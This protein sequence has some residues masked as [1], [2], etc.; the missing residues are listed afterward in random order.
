MRCSTWELPQP[1]QC[2][3]LLRTLQ[4]TASMAQL[5]GDAALDAGEAFRVVATASASG[6]TSSTQAT[7]SP[8]AIRLAAPTIAD[9]ELITIVL[10]AGVRITWGAPSGPAAGTVTYYYK[11]TQDTLLGG[12]RVISEGS[13]TD[14]TVDAAFLGLTVLGVNDKVEVEVRAAASGWTASRYVKYRLT[15]QGAL[16][17]FVID[18]LT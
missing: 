12:R 7:L 8:I 15:Y 10:A 13:G 18:L 4:V 14:S 9:A 17:G 5:S 6:Y 1:F 11:L 3:A 2:T 16:L